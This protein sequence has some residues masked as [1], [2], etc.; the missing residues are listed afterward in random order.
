MSLEE[1]SGLTALLRPAP[2][3]TVRCRVLA[4]LP[5]LRSAP[6]RGE[7]GRRERVLGSTLRRFGL[8]CVC[9]AA[10]AGA[11]GG[12]A[13]VARRERSAQTAARPFGPGLRFVADRRRQ[14][15]ADG[16]SVGLA[17]TKAA[18]IFDGGG[19]GRDRGGRAGGVSR[20][21]G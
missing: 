18:Q 2:K 7:V 14:V 17:R 20:G 5:R 6:D 15:R 1:E 3:R 16:A 12:R 9:I 8:R 21:T 10:V 11:R 4:V 19:G 13:G